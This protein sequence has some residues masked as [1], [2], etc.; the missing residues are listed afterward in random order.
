[1]TTRTRSFVKESPLINYDPKL[2]KVVDPNTGVVYSTTPTALPSRA[3]TVTRKTMNDVVIENFHAR[4]KNGEIFN[5]PMDSV[6]NVTMYNDIE[7][8]HKKP[9]GKSSFVYEWKCSSFE[10]FSSVDLSTVGTVIDKELSQN[11]SSTQAWANVDLSTATALC[12]A[13][14]M[15]K[16]IVSMK[17]ILWRVYKIAKAL[18]KADVKY[19]KGQLTR[20]EILNRYMELRYAIRPLVIDAEQL[21]DTVTREQVA[22]RQT[23]RGY[24]AQKDSFAKSSR[25]YFNQ[26]DWWNSYSD[27]FTL[28]RTVDR[29]F[30]VRSGI[31]C[32]IEKLTTHNAYGLDQILE[33]AWELIPLSFILSWFYDIGNVLKALTPEVGLKTLSSWQVIIDTTIV[34]DRI[35]HVNIDDRVGYDSS[36]TDAT[37]DVIVTSVERIP[38]LNKSFIPRIDVKLDKFKILDLGII[39]SKFLK[40]KF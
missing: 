23:F 29:T 32:Q 31:L 19:L 17:D 35:T 11:L 18:W 36:Y 34:R 8:W 6:T 1:M 14:E 39:L 28:N 22:D 24:N 37:R 5:N 9:Y 38:T 3:R 27:K 26:T 33:T 40:L 7:C 30:I 4:S 12:T 2:K 10:M 21:L 13:A 20:E 15:N 25:Q 16:T